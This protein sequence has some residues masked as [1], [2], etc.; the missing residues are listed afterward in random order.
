MILLFIVLGFVE[1]NSV[2]G[3]I[4]YHCTGVSPYDSCVL[5]NGVAVGCDKR[6]CTIIRRE[7]HDPPGTLVYFLRTCQNTPQY[8]NAEVNDSNYRTFY[9]ACASD[10]CNSGEG[11]LTPNSIAPIKEEQGR[12]LVVPGIT[13]NASSVFPCYSILFCALGSLLLLLMS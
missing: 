13:S 11:R 7:F 2:N 8:I 10:L 3:L 1:I 4:C 5:D 9:H 6:W 12:V